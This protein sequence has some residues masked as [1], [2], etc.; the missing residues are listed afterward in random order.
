MA[1]KEEQLTTGEQSSVKTILLVEDDASIGEV[2]VQAIAQETT[3]MAFLA[4]DGLEALHIVKGIKPNLFILDYQLP[5]MNGLEL[6]DQL[7]AIEALR[8]I[9]VIMLSARLPQK[10][11]E[12]RHIVGMHKPIDLDEFLRLIEELVV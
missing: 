2:L 8:H 6:Y 9:P 5:H 7:H 11:L 4:T 1:Q 12:K 10:E 3:Y